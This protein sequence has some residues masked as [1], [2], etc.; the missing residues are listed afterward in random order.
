MLEEKLGLSSQVKRPKNN[1]GEGGQTGKEQAQPPGFQPTPSC[2]A[3]M[4]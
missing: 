4:L 3:V 2:R 1:G